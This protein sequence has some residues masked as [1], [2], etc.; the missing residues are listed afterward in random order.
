MTYDDGG[1]GGEYNP[2][3]PLKTNAAF[4]PRLKHVYSVKA[5][6]LNTVKNCFLHKI[7][8]RI[9][10]DYRFSTNESI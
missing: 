8:F 3:P 10:A 4:T 5:L 9:F 1:G 2:G 7:C 6:Y